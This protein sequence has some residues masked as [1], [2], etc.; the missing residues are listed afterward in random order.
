VAMIGMWANVDSQMQ[1]GY[2]GVPPYLHSPFDAAE[3]LCFEVVY[4]NGSI[5][6]STVTVNMAQDTLT[7][8]DISAIVLYFGGTDSS[9]EGEAMD[10]YFVAWSPAQLDLNLQNIC[11]GKAIHRD[12]SK[13][14]VSQM[15]F[16]F[17]RISIS[18]LSYAGYPGQDGRTSSFCHP[19]RCTEFC[20]SKPLS[21]DMWPGGCVPSSALS[22]SYERSSWPLH[23][24]IPSVRV[25]SANPR[26]KPHRRN[27]HPL[28]F[29]TAL[30]GL[31]AIRGPCD[32]SPSIVGPEL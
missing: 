18:Q 32:N 24:K 19:D 14:V 23:P 8:A 4:T 21:P 7:V 20:E 2:I 26:P 10:R 22:R 9:I 1:A 11:S 30:E 6:D 12:Q 5:N 31:E 29:D 13:W 3:K 17:S 25:H 16:R 28:S 27:H 15:T